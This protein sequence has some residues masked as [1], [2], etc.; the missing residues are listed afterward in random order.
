MLS[1][2]EKGHGTVGGQAILVVFS[3][4]VTLHSFL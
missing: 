3:N 2:M 4:Y 1:M